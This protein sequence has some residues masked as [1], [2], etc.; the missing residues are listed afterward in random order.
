MELTD[1]LSY[2]ALS[3]FGGHEC[4]EDS[5]SE[6]N[7]DDYDDNSSSDVDDDEGE[8]SADELRPTRNFSFLNEAK[9]MYAFGVD[10]NSRIKNHTVNKRML[11][12]DRS[13][14]IRITH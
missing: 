11:L 8:A 4:S 2:E 13:S 14:R 7:E 5:S 12:T 1:I 3:N 10:R 6:S 9:I